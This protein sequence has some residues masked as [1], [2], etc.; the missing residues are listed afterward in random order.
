MAL[1]WLNAGKKNIYTQG[2]AA[3]LFV[4]VIWTISHIYFLYHITLDDILHS[5]P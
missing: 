3:F 2:Q 1:H 4:C 5:I